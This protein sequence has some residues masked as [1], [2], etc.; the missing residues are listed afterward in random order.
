MWGLETR[1]REIRVLGT[2]S[3]GRGGVKTG[4]QDIKYRDTGDTGCE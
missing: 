2:S 4:T 3:M 1:G